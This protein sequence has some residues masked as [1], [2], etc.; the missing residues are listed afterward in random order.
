MP[1]TVHAADVLEGGARLLERMPPESHERRSTTQFVVDALRRV[2]RD[3]DA[4]EGARCDALHIARAMF[5]Q[6][7][8]CDRARAICALRGAAQSA[9][10]SA[11]SEGAGIPGERGFPGIGSG[12]TL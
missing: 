4:P 6:L 11:Q 8:E 3:L 1:C 12:G 7:P 9:R 10:G 5:Q 2:G